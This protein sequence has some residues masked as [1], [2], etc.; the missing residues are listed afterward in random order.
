[1]EDLEQIDR[2]PILRWDSWAWFGLAAILFLPVFVD[3]INGILIYKT[4]SSFSFGVIYRGGLFVGLVAFLFL[5]KEKWLTL[6]W[7]ILV[8]LFLMGFAVWSASG[9]IKPGYEISVIIKVFFP[10]VLLGFLFFINETYSVTA[11]QLINLFLGFCIVAALAIVFSLI[12][13]IGINTYGDGEVSYTYGTKSLFK[14][15]NDMGITHLVGSPFALYKLFK[16]FG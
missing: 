15:Q 6:Y 10:T 5:I 11:D 2:K 14:A 3:L 12:T 1:M 7:G 9:P 8:S 4:N 13:G 16:N